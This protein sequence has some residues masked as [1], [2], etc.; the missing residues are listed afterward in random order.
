MSGVYASPE[1]SA[2]WNA[3]WVPSGGALELL[4]KS[5]LRLFGGIVSLSPC[6]L[7]TQWIV[8]FLS[9]FP[10]LERRNVEVEEKKYLLETGFVT[11]TQ[12]NMGM[13]E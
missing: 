3:S 4:D 10:D 9:P 11:E 1:R 6:S 12:S 2:G 13:V 5:V 8:L 7:S